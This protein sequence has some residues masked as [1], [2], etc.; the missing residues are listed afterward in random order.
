VDDSALQRVAS[1]MGLNHGDLFGLVKAIVWVEGPMDQ[2]VIDALCGDE[3]RR[4]GVHVAMYGG[5]GN[6][7][8]VL[9]NPLARLPDLRFV[10]LVD[11]LD[12][13]QLALVT[14]SPE[15]VEADDSHEMR[16]TAVLIRRAKAADRQLEIVSHGAADVFLTLSDAALAEIARRPWPGKDVVLREADRMNIRKSRLKGFVADRYGLQVDAARCGYA[17]TLMSQGETP[18]WIQDLLAAADAP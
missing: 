1:E 7:R 3:M 10:V 4:R 2:A 8:S 6:I 17:A 14:T 12:A 5:L 11:D 13:E 18:T 16:E 15:L 9:D